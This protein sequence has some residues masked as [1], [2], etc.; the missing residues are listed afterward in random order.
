MKNKSNVLNA[1]ARQNKINTSSRESA[2]KVL[3][4]IKVVNEK[5]NITN[6]YSNSS[7]F[8]IR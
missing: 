5:E 1:L 4:R 3:K 6:N 2:V 8:V 7:R